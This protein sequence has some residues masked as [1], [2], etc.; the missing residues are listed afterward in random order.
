VTI[1]VLSDNVL[2][3]IFDFYKESCESVPD[4][5]AWRWQT[6]A[7]VCRRW[8]HI[9]LASPLRLELRVA[10]NIRTPTR[11]S[12]DIWPPFPIC[13]TCVP[14]D[15][16][17]AQGEE[18]I[19]AALEQRD[20]VSEIVLLGPT[21]TAFKL[22]RFT[23]VMEEPLPVLTHLCLLSSDMTK[24]VLSEAF[25]GGSAPRLRLL[26]LQGIPFPALPTLVLS[27]SHFHSLHLFDVPHAGYISPHAMVAFLHALPNLKFL[28]IEFR[29]PQSRPFQI[30]PPPFTRA[31]LPALVDFQFQGVSE[32]LDEFVSRIDTPLINRLQITLFLDP[33]F[34]IPRL[35]KFI[36]R[37]ET[38][39]P[40]SQAEAKLSPGGIV[41]VLG[42]PTGFPDALRLEITCNMSDWQ[43]LSMAR[44]CRQLMPLLSQVERLDVCESYWDLLE[45]QCDTDYTPWLELL[46]PLVSLK[47]LYVSEK[48]VPLVAPALQ[49]LTEESVTDV[50]PALHEL[51]LEGL[52]PSGSVLEALKP[53]VTARQVSNPV[54]IQRWERMPVSG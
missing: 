20:R 11:K 7:H 22:E 18:N 37:T 36:D 31:V 10:C 48:L 8:R 44:V 54:V 2:L 50:L 53:F 32:Y 42:S 38:L 4:P 27:A 12:L 21:G 30:T 49:G 40:L 29:D 47:S 43:D 33:F 5:A 6:L 25:L 16:I 34:D 24:M 15:R 9:I 3:E 23:A 19:I 35:Y 28:T 17:D 26:A 14:L 39:K 52:Q 41:A 13:I 46:Y 1:D 45:W 51:F